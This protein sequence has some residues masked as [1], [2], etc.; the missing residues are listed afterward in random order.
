MTTRRSFLRIMGSGAV[1]LAAPVTVSACSGEPSKATMPWKTAGQNYQDFRMRALSYAI[2]APNPHNRQPW[3]V[4]LSVEDE[5][6]LY[7]DQTRLLPNTDPFNR[8]I[9][10]GLGCFLELLRIAAYHDNYE[11]LIDPFPEGEPGDYI[12]ERPIA[13]VRFAQMEHQKV[14][15]LWR[16]VLR[17]R[18]NRTTFDTERPVEKGML[19]V[20]QSQAMGSARIGTTNKMSEVSK[21][22][23]FTYDAWVVESKT[24][25]THME[26]VNLMR[27]GSREIDAN[28]DGISI[29]GLAPEV[30]KSIGLLTREKM[31]NPDAWAS[32]QGIEIYGDAVKTAM[33]FVWCVTPGNSRVDQLEAGY[34]WVRINLMANLLELSLHPLSQSLQEFEEMRFHYNKI[35][36]KLCTQPGEQVQMFGRLGYAKDVKPSPRWP[37]DARI[38]SV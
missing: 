16:A 28:P 21:W 5:A 31:A 7:C 32:R 8:Q 13:R 24:K 19:N 1:I 4:D 36:R 34:S 10:V 25:R 30:M 33:A 20:L 22:R 26:S 37:L 2:L 35:H 12:D 15:P 17:R 29:G 14:E 18:T 3:L 23:Q 6:T 11:V 38:L 9:V 27:I